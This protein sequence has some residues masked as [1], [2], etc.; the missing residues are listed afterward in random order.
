MIL[1]KKPDNL[2]ALASL[3]CLI[4]CL[5]TPFIFVAQTCSIACCANAPDWWKSIDI[6]FLTISFFAV[7]AS[8]NNSKLAWLKIG[9][10]M[11]WTCLF[12]MI[13]NENILLFNLPHYWIYLPSFML[14]FLHLYH[15]K[16]CSCKHNSCCIQ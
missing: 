1:T 15:K 8:S 14:I 7:Y 12:L 3:L 4:H 5:I 16:H 9:L 13:L 2:G 10:W 11:S 6:F